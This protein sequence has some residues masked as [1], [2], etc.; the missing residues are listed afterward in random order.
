[1][2]HHGFKFMLAGFIMTCMLTFAS[3]HVF[4]RRHTYTIS[5]S[6]TELSFEK[7]SGYDVIKLSGRH[8]M[9]KIGE[10]ALPVRNIYVALPGDVHITDLELVSFNVEEISGKYH[11]YPAQPPVPTKKGATPGPFVQP[12]ASIYNNSESYPK[13][14]IRY[15]GTGS[16]GGQKIAMLQVYPIQYIPS[17]G[18]LKFYDQIKFN[19]ITKPND[20]SPSIILKSYTAQ[21]VYNQISKDLVINPEDIAKNP[22]YALPSV[23]FF[24]YL[25]IT[26]DALVSSFQPLAEWKTKKG[27]PAVIRTTSWINSNYSGSD[28]PER[29]RNYLKIAYQDSGTVWVLLGGDTEIVPCRYVRIVFETYTEDIPCDLYYSDLDGNWNYDSDSWYGEPEDSLDMFPDVF[30]GRAPISTIQQAE[31]F[32]NKVFTYSRTPTTDYQLKGLFFA[33]YMDAQTD[34]GIAKDIIIDRYIPQSFGPV[35]RLY[36]RFGNLNAETVV[37]SLNAGFN[38]ANHCGHAWYDLLCTGPNYVWSWDFD[39]L[40]NAPKYT[41]ILVSG[42]CWPAAIDYDCI[43]EHFVNAPNGGGFFIGNSRYGWFSPSFPGYGSSDLF[44]Q[45]FFSE[46]FLKS[47]PQLGVALAGS[48]LLYAADAQSVNDYRWICFALILLGDPEMALW[49]DEPHTLTLHYADTIVVGESEFLVSV[50]R[51]DQP[52]EDALI[53]VTKGDEV[54]ESGLSGAD[55]QVRLGIFPTSAGTLSITVTAPNFLPHQCYSVVVADKPHITYCNYVIDDSFGNNDGIVNSGERIGLFLNLTNSG[56]QT[57]YAVVGSLSTSSALVEVIQDDLADYG[58]MTGGDMATGEFSFD[59]S[60]TAS[61]RDV[62]YFNLNVTADGGLSWNPQIA[63]TVGAPVLVYWRGIINDGP[64]GDGFADPSDTVSLQ[65]T[66]KNEGL[67]NGEGTYGVLNT[68]D[69]YIDILSDSAWF[70]NLGP[71]EGA[72]SDIP[73]ELAISGT[74]PDEHIAWLS[75]SLV[76]EN[77]STIDSFRL[78]VG[79]LRFFDDVESGP[80]GWIHSG[81]IDEWHITTHRSYSEQHSWYC[82]NEGTWQYSNGF[83]A[84]LVSAPVVLAEDFMLSF[85]TWHYIESG[86]DYAFCEIDPGE[87]WRELGLI[88]GQSG[89]WVQKTYD[90]SEYAGDTVQISFTFFSDDDGAQFEGWYIDDIKII[91]QTPDFMCGDCNGDGT[92]DLGDVL[93]I[94]SYLYKGGPAPDPLEAGDCNCDDTIDLGDLLYLVAY[95]YKGGPAPVC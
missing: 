87:G 20:Q 66:V 81:T 58:D 14:I 27:I 8:F 82:G 9:N 11:I 54:Y 51:S 30:V 25:I 86:W 45:A 26:S 4:A 48:K 16:L 23:D 33:E 71:G 38:I 79:D 39:N 43:G 47:K 36:E 35:D 15:V 95:L 57:A 94:V 78:F 3:S 59:V 31:G 18:I 76:G 55:G 46:V 72:I 90:L 63:V 42:G 21:S 93:H 1:M 40:N 91:P 60:S 10:P 12:K 19:L 68:D 70:G 88:T 77:Y 69:S 5:S 32:V 34:Q 67:G 53:C 24:E 61:D 65:V 80:G 49:T 73:Y 22:N 89:G 64:D 62:I 28:L 17:E 75:I 52:V 6:K 13:D 7:V 85:W 56:N 44:D 50:T 2:R 92:I 29:I 84:Y 74:C 41:G 83:T 37:D